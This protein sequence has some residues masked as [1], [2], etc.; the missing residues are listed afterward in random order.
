MPDYLSWGLHDYEKGQQIHRIVLD[1]SFVPLAYRMYQPF[2]IKEVVIER[3][4][5]EDLQVIINIGV[6]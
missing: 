1:R 2:K 6:A 3:T 5:L 4:F